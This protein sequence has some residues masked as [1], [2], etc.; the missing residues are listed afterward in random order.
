MSAAHDATR[1]R[2]RALA[3]LTILATLATLAASAAAAHAAVHSSTLAVIGDTPYDDT[4][5]SAFPNL[6]K[7]INDDAHVGVV[8]HLGDIKGSQVCSDAFFE[9]RYKLFHTFKDPF[10][11]TPGDNEWTDCGRAKFGGYIPTERLAALRRVFYPTP[12]LAT[13]SQHELAVSPQSK[14]HG[15]GQFVENVLWK[16]SDVVIST[17]HVVGSNNDLVSWF[18]AA[19]TPEQDAL[20]KAEFDGRLK[21][22][23]EWLDHTF[24]VAQHDHA[25][26]IVIAM[27]A[28]TFISR[29]FEGAAVSGFTDVLRH[30]AYLASRYPYPVLLLQGDSHSF[31][32]DHP[33]THGSPEHHVSSHAPNVTRIVVQGET[34][35]EWLSLHIDP[36]A[37]H[38]FTW[39]RKHLQSPL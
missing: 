35:D 22:D 30:L 8:L 33:L 16:Q 36:H 28:N 2:G 12:S 13:G 14:Q 7:H 24:A 5:E 10:V 39:K 18:G 21:A 25:V 34:S 20:Q 27:Q 37:T 9:S 6:V 3:R 11:F 15:F 17:L 4:Q 23:L 32:A 38:P 26:G 1:G 31:I 29:L 19:Q